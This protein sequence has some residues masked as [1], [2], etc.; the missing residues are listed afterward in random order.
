MSKFEDLMRQVRASIREVPPAQVNRQLGEGTP[1]HLLDVR[2]K[3]EFD[4]G[5]VK[6]ALFIPRGFL[7]IKVEDA[8]PDKESPVIVYC[9]G[10]VRSAMAAKAM[11]D[12][13]YTNVLSMSGGFG[14]WKRSGFPFEMTETN[15]NQDKF[16]SRYD[17]HIKLPE[18][19]EAGQKK[20]LK[21]KV[22]LIGA[23]GLGCPAAYYLAAAGVGTLGIIDFDVV[24]E[25]NLQ[26]QI[27]HSTFDAGRP[28]V[29]SAKETLVALNPDVK[30]VG[31]QERLSSENTMEI[32]KDYDLVVDGS[33]NFP[34]RYLVNDACVLLRK[35]VIYGA[36]ERFVGQASVFVPFDTPCY[37]CLYPAPPPPDLA[38]NCAEAGVLGVLPGVIGTIQATEALKVLLN[39]GEPLK[40]RLL[41]YDAKKMSFR[42]V[43]LHR[44]S[45]CPVCGPEASIHKLIDYEAFCAST[46]H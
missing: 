33:D 42:T 44:D 17:R 32:F 31:Y 10:G 36:I 11:Q 19:G 30:V 46:A 43:K 8:I 34:T 5:H 3:D 38:P 2:E 39:I 16:F 45:K 4:A 12:L 6:G 29:Q 18:I 28:K 22:L 7:E 1:V 27:L 26:R 25:S 24:D 9:Q 35:P 23:G 40:N 41:L 20:L 13:G 37:R 21:S 15:G 14:L